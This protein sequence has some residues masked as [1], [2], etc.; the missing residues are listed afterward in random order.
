MKIVI[1]ILLMCILSTKIQ[2]NEYNCPSLPI[3]GR[4]GGKVLNGWEIQFQYNGKESGWVYKYYQ[5]HY[6]NKYKLDSWF[7]LNFYG[8]PER[9]EYLLQCCSLSGN[10]HTICVGKVVKSKYCKVAEGIN[11]RKFICEN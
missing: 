11:E 7:G 8:Y 10:K 2:A 6:G 5:K 4:V 3:V 9:H 1:K